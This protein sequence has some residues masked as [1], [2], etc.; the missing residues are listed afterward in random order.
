[1]IIIYF[2]DLSRGRR[3]KLMGATYRKKKE[4]EDLK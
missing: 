3:K 4:S 2:A 1:M